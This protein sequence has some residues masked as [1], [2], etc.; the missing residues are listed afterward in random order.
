MAKQKQMTEKELDRVSGGP[1]IRNFNG[2]TG[3]IGNRASRH[4][5]HPD[6][7]QSKNGKPSI[8]YTEV[9]WT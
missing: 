2:R 5:V 1:H 7:L 4:I 8:G 9:E 3:V 6:Y